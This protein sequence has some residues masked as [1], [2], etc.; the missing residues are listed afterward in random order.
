MS[1]SHQSTLSVQLRTSCTVTGI[2]IARTTGKVLA[3]QLAIL[4][5]ALGIHEGANGA[6]IALVPQKQR[7]RL[8][9][10]I[11]FEVT[12]LDI[13][14]CRYLT[15]VVNAKRN[16]VH[17]RRVSSNKEPAKDNLLARVNLRVQIGQL[18]NIIRNHVQQ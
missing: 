3:P 12:C 16:R 6:Q 14:Y 2:V 4:I 8:A 7:L 5:D 15:P 9:L 11:C 13:S 18:G 1:S 10:N 17:C